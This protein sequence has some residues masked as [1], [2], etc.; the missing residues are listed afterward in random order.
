[1]K[2]LNKYLVIVA[3][4]AGLSPGSLSAKQ[5][6]NGKVGIEHWSAKGIAYLYQ[7]SLEQCR[8]WVEVKDSEYWVSLPWA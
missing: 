6:N 2:E 7:G 5:L 8:I 1:M 3:I 4:E